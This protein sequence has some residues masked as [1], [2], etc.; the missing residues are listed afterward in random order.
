MSRGMESVTRHIS[1]LIVILAIVQFVAIFSLPYDKS[2]FY[3]FPMIFAI[4][5]L[6]L[7]FLGAILLRLRKSPGIFVCSISL[8]SLGLCFVIEGILLILTGPSIIVGTLYAMLG[9]TSFRRIASLN[10]TTY[11]SW[12]E[13][14]N[15]INPINLENEEVIAACP[16]CSSVLAVIPSLLTK[17]DICP[18][19][20][21]KLVP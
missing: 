16:H 19:C 21:G 13:G 7:S 2:I 12:F 17:N 4:I 15:S 5:S 1:F 6:P 14:K 9:I 20:N 8:G 11:V 10:N 18:E 3:I